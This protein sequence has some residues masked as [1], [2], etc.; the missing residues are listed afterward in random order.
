MI[1]RRLSHYRVT[2]P[3]GSGGMGVVYCAQDEHL[4]REVALKVLPEGALADE[5]TRAR[6]RREA[7]ALSRLNHPSIGTIFDFDTEDGLDFLVMEYVPGANL[8]ARLAGGSLPEAEAVALAIQIAEALEA[9]HEQGIVHR[10]LK[11]ANVMV[12]ERG[13]V[14][15][16]DFGVAKLRERQN[17]LVTMGS[18]GTPPM[19]GTLPYMAPEQLLGGAVDARADLFAFGALLFEMT[20]GR[21]AFPAAVEAALVNEIINHPPT[22]PRQLRSEISPAIEAIILRCLEKDPVR[23]PSSAGAIAG[24]LATI[25]RPGRPVPAGMAAPIES[26]AVLPLENLSRD[27]EHEYFADGMT[28]ALISDL[29]K[30]RALRVISRTSV[31]RFKG[32]HRPVSEI[33]RELGVDAVV[34]GTVLRAGDRVRVSAQL[35]HAASDR[36]LWAERYERDVADVLGIQSELAQAIVREIQVTMTQ[37]ER[38]QLERV[39]RVDP[40]AHEAYLKGRHFWNMRTGPE[41]NRA[42][43]LFRQAIDLDPTYAPAYSG[44]ADCFNILADRNVYPPPVAFPQAKAAALRALGLDPQLAE[45]HA[46]LGYVLAAHEW[47]WAGAEREYVQAIELDRGYPTAHQWYGILL[48]G[49]GRFDEGIAHTL[50][51]VRRDP[52]S[53]ILYSTAGDAYYYARRYDDAIAQYRKVID[54]DPA[55]HLV[56][57]DLGRT[58]EQTGR[59]DEALEQYEI[60]FQGNGGDRSVSPAIACTLGFA[61]RLDEART[62]LAA[63]LKKAKSEYVPPYAI[64]SIHAS[65]GEIDEGLSA[66]E[67]AFEVRDRAMMFLQVN[68]RFDILRSNARF[69]ALVE[70]MKFPNRGRAA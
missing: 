19:V 68:P 41:L 60:G 40:D 12:T 54:F 4:E 67:K 61:G 30:V 31:M 51:S 15:V 21:R 9:A 11:P 2:A 39:R 7:L 16:L 5:A 6:F 24:E 63:I 8:A 62:M 55:F 17:A 56:R 23:R 25:T 46:S 53:R 14:K 65:L 58:L 42:I 43:G 70:R 69:G 28:E 1:G 20:T 26:L 44:L 10:D 48:S 59:Y 27:P 29:A 45:A 37:Q 49:L 33:A 38:A 47:D 32:V 3:L 35:I 57:F 34:E 22:H 64:A 18:S 13:R 52:L 36:H 66:L 50:E